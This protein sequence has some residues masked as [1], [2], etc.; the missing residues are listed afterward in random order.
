MRL[1]KIMTNVR[2]VH[3]FINFLFLL[4]KV[5]SSCHL[6]SMLPPFPTKEKGNKSCWRWRLSPAPIIPT[7][8]ICHFDIIL[9][10]PF[11]TAVLE[12]IWLFSPRMTMSESIWPVYL[13]SSFWFNHFLEIV[14]IYFPSKHFKERSTLVNFLKLLLLQVDN[15]TAAFS[16]FPDMS[17]IPKLWRLFILSPALMCHSS[18]QCSAVE[19]HCSKFHNVKMSKFKHFQHLNF[20]NKILNF[21]IFQGKIVAQGKLL[22]RGPLFCTDDPT[23]GPNFKMREMTVFLFEQ[24]PF[25]S[26]LLTIYI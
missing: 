6:V 14:V 7:P 4:S 12:T 17:N 26:L 3:I 19:D 20:W 18:N 21:L 23:S 9:F 1:C 10:K 5:L 25:I 15:P 11:F 2:Y 22:L 24:V 13:S 8:C 16:N